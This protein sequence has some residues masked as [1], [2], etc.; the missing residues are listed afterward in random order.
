VEGS[1][2]VNTWTGSLHGIQ[3]VA[4]QW[5]KLQ[6]YRFYVLPFLQR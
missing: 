6:Y 5:L 4:E 1:V 2:D 3:N